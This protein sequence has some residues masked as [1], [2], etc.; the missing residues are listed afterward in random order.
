MSH[1]ALSTPLAWTHPES[2]IGFAA[3]ENLDDAAGL[4]PEP[5]I[6]HSGVDALKR[7]RQRSFLL[8]QLD[9]LRY[10]HELK[11]QRPFLAVAPLQP[12]RQCSSV[13][14]TAEALALTFLPCVATW[15]IEEMP[16]DG[17]AGYCLASPRMNYVSGSDLGELPCDV[18]TM[19]C[20]VCLDLG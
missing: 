2:S 4:K 9:W 13:I 5:S 16:H 11:L 3:A 19:I 12:S 8:S 10:E 15:P 7:L 1:Y 18:E 6:S 20:A 17:A 14:A